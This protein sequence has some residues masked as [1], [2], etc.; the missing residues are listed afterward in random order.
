MGRSREPIQ[1]QVLGRQTSAFS[2]KEKPTSRVHS[3]TVSDP[4]IIKVDTRGMR[5]AAVKVRIPK[6]IAKVSCTQMHITKP[7]RLSVGI[8]Q[9]IFCISKL[10]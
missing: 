6:P 7:S 3:I 2:L 5:A 1:Y 4:P 10:D 8:Q 9:P